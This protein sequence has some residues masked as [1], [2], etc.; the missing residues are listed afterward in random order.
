MEKPQHYQMTTIQGVSDQIPPR[1]EQHVDRMCNG[2]LKVIQSHHCWSD[3]NLIYCDSPE[4][5]SANELRPGVCVDSAHTQPAPLQALQS[6]FSA[7]FTGA[8]GML[9]SPFVNHMSGLG[10]SPGMIDPE[11][12]EPIL[13]N[14]T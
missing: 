13:L 14:R 7:I 11:L 3:R 1:K 10:S 6:P 9:L 4:P 2:N 12:W 8:E 5:T